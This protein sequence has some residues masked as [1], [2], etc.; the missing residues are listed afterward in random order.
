MTPNLISSMRAG[1]KGG[2]L[3]D[4][5]SKGKGFVKANPKAALGTGF[6]G[7]TNIAGLTDN[8]KV[9]G[10]LAGTALGAA[11]PAIIQRVTGMPVNLGKLGRVN[12]A[13]GGGALGSL[14]DTLRSKKAQA[15]AA[16]TGNEEYVPDTSTHAY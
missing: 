12:L 4:L 10:Q 3:K 16:P 6:L 13:M 7:V 14:F 9:L 11:A 2:G 1:T 15:T 5:F 8:D